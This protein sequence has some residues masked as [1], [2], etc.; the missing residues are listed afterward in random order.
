[1]HDGEAAYAGAR[2]CLSALHIA[3]KRIVIL[4]NSSRRAGPCPHS[5]TVMRET[6]DLAVW[7]LT[8][9]P[10]VVGNPGALQNAGI[11]PPLWGSLLGPIPPDPNHRRGCWGAPLTRVGPRAGGAFIICDPRYNPYRQ[12]RL[13]SRM[14]V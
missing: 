11:S 13:V 10:I 1:M 5:Y 3:G 4:S 2:E 9:I 12:I 6:S 7:D 8:R 14:S